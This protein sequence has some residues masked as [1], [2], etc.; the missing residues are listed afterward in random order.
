M[1]RY[2]AFDPPEYRDW[3]PD[4]D[5]QAEFAARLIELG[6]RHFRVEFLNEDHDEVTRTLQQYRRL[7]DGEIDGAALWRE[8]KLINQLGVTRGQIDAAPRTMLPK[9]GAP[10]VRSADGANAVGVKRK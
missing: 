10:G 3:K 7:L 1:I 6:A 4:A 2:P 9:G 5:A 8:F